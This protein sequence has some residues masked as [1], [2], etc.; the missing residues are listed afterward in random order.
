ME[1]R[2]AKNVEDSKVLKAAKQLN[3]AAI[4][5][6]AGAF[7]GC[8]GWVVTPEK[9]KQQ[10]APFWIAGLG[11]VGFLFNRKIVEIRNGRL[12]VGDLNAVI[13]SYIL[14]RPEEEARFA[15]VAEYVSGDK[16]L[17]DLPVIR[18]TVDAAVGQKVSAHVEN[19]DRVASAREALVRREIQ[20]ATE[21]QRILDP[22]WEAP[23]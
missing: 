20:P 10:I 7:I 23:V 9:V 1:I 15:S 18:D 2:E 8:A 11:G 22:A 6:M 12:A 21:P 14:M 3:I 4:A 17:T 16:S 19:F 5:L 13:A